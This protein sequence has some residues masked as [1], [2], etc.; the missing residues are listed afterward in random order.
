MLWREL[1]FFSSIQNLF[2]NKVGPGVSFCSR[3]LPVPWPLACW[4]FGPWSALR[5]GGA[6]SKCLDTSPPW[7]PESNT[8]PQPLGVSRASWSKVRILPLAFRRLRVHTPQFGLPWTRVSWV[9]VPSTTA[10][11]P[12]PGSFIF[13]IL[14][15]GQARSWCD[16]WTTSSAPY[17]WRRSWFLWAQV[18][19]QSQADVLLVGSLPNLLVV[20]DLDS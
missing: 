17:G 20:A 14:G 8:V 19:Q 3:G 1:I 18:D 2:N 6:L 9:I 16:L 7:Q 4:I 12:S 13:L 10:V 11:L 15:K 5:F